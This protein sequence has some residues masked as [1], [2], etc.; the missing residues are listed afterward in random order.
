M[1]EGGSMVG[2][3]VGRISRGGSGV[4]REGGKEG[5]EGAGLGGR[6]GRREGGRREGR[7]GGRAVACK[8]SMSA[9]THM[10]THTKRTHTCTRMHKM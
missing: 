10:L 4:G 6:E 1:A 3:E 7:G 8:G 5:S 9:C 2:S